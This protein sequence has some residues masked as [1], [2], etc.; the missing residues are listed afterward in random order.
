MSINRTLGQPVR[1]KVGLIILLV[2]AGL[3]TLL[4]LLL[5]VS[6]DEPILFS[7]Y[8]AF[9]L[10][11]LLVIALPLRRHERWAW[12]LT[13]VLP[14]G[15]AIPASLDRDIAPLYYAVAAVCVVGLLLSR[16]SV[17]AGDRGGGA[18]ISPHS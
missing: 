3:L 8:T 12:Y 4:H 7:G 17:F 15:L 10:Y 11:A 2:A 14:L 16:R 5:M 6:L 1:F 9:N 13:W 18:L